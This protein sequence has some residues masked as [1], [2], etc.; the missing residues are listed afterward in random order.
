MYASFHKTLFALA[1]SLILG[2]GSIYDMLSPGIYRDT[3]N[4]GGEIALK[5]HLIQKS[6]FI[7]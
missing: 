6:H 3:E 1:T 2:R 7:D 4:S 5:D